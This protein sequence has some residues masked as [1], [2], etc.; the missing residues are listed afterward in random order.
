VESAQLPDTGDRAKG[1][2]VRK[3]LCAAG[4]SL[5]LLLAAC[6]STDDGASS[7]SE[8]PT[9]SATTGLG[10]S[11]TSTG[12]GSSDAAAPGVT[13]DSIKV[14]V[15]YVDLSRIG[16]ILKVDHGDYEK[17][18]R[19]VFDDINA[20]GGING[21]QLE[22]VFAP[23][24]PIGTSGGDAAC[25][26]LTQ[27]ERVFVAVG[28]FLG[29][30]VLC[31]V[32]TNDTPVL[33]GDMNDE[34]LERAKAAW[35]TLEPSDDLQ[36]DVIRAMDAAGQLDGKVAVVGMSLDQGTLD[37]KIKPVLDELGVNVVATALNDAPT[38]DA[39]A[40]YAAAATIAERFK[41][42]GAD[43]VLVIGPG[44]APGWLTGLSQT[45]YRPQM[46]FA[47]RNSVDTY[48]GDPA[49]LE[50]STTGAT[51]DA[52]EVFDTLGDPSKECYDIQRAAGLVLLPNSQVAKGETDQFVSSSAACRYMYL[53]KAILEKA[54][55]D[56]NRATFKAAGD[57]LG[58]VVLPGSPD[59]FM[60]GPPP[61]A[62]GDPK[63]Y[64]YDWDVATAGFV[65]AKS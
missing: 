15:S 22:P 49:L 28:F 33:G 47:V 62:D 34:R 7:T 25:T 36:V 65:P 60:F 35:Y 55:T 44:T 13:A 40:T 24:N 10:G 54:G 9:S 42:A 52:S 17:A 23:V 37:T 19:A 51:F 14:G 59:P 5:L 64:L 18:Y 30:N 3:Y 12:G 41:A 29:D 56:L 53:L 11:S 4:A 16:D 39:G 57:S 26:K 31:Y 46:R 61:S 45:D 32:E 21:R 27:D 50:G 63:V 48:T 1:D 38:N 2:R 58:E 8:A 43:Q 6:K 20:K